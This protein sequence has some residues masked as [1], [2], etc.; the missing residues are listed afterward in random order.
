MVNKDIYVA[1]SLKNYTT[2]NGEANI[3]ELTFPV[4]SA[5]A[6]NKITYHVTGAKKYYIGGILYDSLP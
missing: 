1:T 6:S 2:E 3:Y 5:T 4:T